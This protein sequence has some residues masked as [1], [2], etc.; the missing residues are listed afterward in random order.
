MTDETKINVLPELVQAIKHN[1]V[2][3]SLL[4][5][6]L[7]QAGSALALLMC[8]LPVDEDKIKFFDEVTK[9][10][11]DTSD[12]IRELTNRM[13]RKLYE[14]TKGSFP[15]IVIPTGRERFDTAIK[16]VE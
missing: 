15:L 13:A 4:E 2:S 10:Y 12:T 1:A 9:L 7:V 11:L 16:E 14:D 5:V 8:S 6:D 3:A